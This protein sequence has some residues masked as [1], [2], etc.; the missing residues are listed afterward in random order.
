MV[1]TGWWLLT[2]FGWTD[3]VLPIG[4]PYVWILFAMVKMLLLFCEFL[5]S[6]TLR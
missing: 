5:S 1:V 4:T 2:V 6:M 3:L